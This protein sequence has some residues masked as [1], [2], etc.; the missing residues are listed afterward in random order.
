MTILQIS[1][2]EILQL[3]LRY[4]GFDIYRQ[5]QVVKSTNVQRFRT[6]FGPLP[7]TASQLFDEIQDP[8]IGEAYIKKPNAVY[9]LM[10]LVWLNLYRTETALAGMFEINEKTVRRW[11]WLYTNAFQAL[12]DKMVIIKIHVP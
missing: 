11:T 3:G 10:T 9:F 2:A 6:T 4:A 7:K 5:Q 1:E 8:S 12:K